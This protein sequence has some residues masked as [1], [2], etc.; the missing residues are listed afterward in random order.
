MAVPPNVA[1]ILLAD[2]AS[3]RRL[4]QGLL[5]NDEAD[6]VV[7]EAAAAAL[8]QPA[9][10]L[11]HPGEWL[12]GTVRKLS[13]LVRRGSARRRARERLAARSGVDPHDPSALVAQAELV[14]DVGAA[15][16]ALDEPFRSA[17]LMRYWH[18][19]SIDAIA[20]RLRVPRNTV[21]SRL[22]RG[23]ARLRERL[24]HEYGERKRWAPALCA[25]LPLHAP[26]FAAFTLCVMNKKVL[27]GASAVL[28]AALAIPFLL[29]E[30]TLQVTPASPT[31]GH[32]AVVTAP[33]LPSAADT[34]GQPAPRREAV[35]GPRPEA[36]TTGTLVVHVQDGSE[37]AGS[38]LT[39]SVGEM[40][41]GRTGDF[42]VGVLRALTD[43]AGTARFE[44]V[45][46]GRVWVRC[47]GGFKGAEVR[48][49]ETVE[50]VLKLG[51]AT[52]TGIVVDA[53]GVGIA[54]ALV[55][56]GLAPENR[57]D[58]EAA[59][60]TAADG[61]FVVRNVTVAAVIGA[62]AHG[63]APSQL[64]HPVLN[65]T[66]ATLRIE[67]AAAGGSVGG[68]VTTAD[69]LPVRDAVVRVGEGRRDALMA[70]PQMPPLPAQVLTDAEGRFLA[71]GVPAGTAPILARAKGLAPWTGTV[72]VAAGL[73]AS[74][75]IRLL[76]GV[77]CA[78]LVRT[79]AGEPAADVAVRCG[80]EGDFLQYFARSA[81]DGSFALTGLPAG[82]IE[83]WA[84]DGERGKAAATV[85]GEHGA[86]VRC[87]LVLSQGLA[88]RGRV[89][90]EDGKPIPSVDLQCMSEG[91]GPRWWKN[92][93]TDKAGRFLVADCPQGRLLTV[94]AWMQDHVPLVRRSIDPKAGELDLKLAADTSPRA[95]ITGRIL[96]PGGVRATGVAVRAF[97]EARRQS[98]DLGLKSDDGTFALEVSA[99][100]WGV[101]VSC[102]GH[103]TVL[104][105]PRRLQPAEAWDLGTIELT[106][107][108]T[109]LVHDGGREGLGYLVL[110]AR[111]Q[112][113]CGI[114]SP[115]TPRR[116]ELLAA[117][118]YLLLVRAKG[119]GAQ[120]L[121]F[122]IRSG[123]ETAIDV[124]P[125]AGVR[126]RF[127]FVPAQGTELPPWVSFRIA[128]DG[129]LVGQ[130]IQE[131]SG[132]PR[133]G[134]V[135]LEPGDYVLTSAVEGREGQAAVTIGQNEGPP[136][137]ITLR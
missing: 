94:K 53:A 88:L 9:A 61:S 132:E 3:L 74:V 12:R 57:V 98:G 43:T 38:D 35:D 81:A 102:E 63:Y 135:W 85:N 121:P 76:P 33:L 66:G 87:E 105:G 95:R 13:L 4:A 34:A 10:S 115:A 18:D 60:I 128:R 84:E 67:L 46:P 109:L 133:R 39:V 51:G 37:P 113:L 93:R 90:E 11:R 89:T 127:E 86:T 50:C 75:T 64:Y 131:D 126:Q 130:C 62:R 27:L 72:D 5:A 106:V 78:G 103:P 36:V 136:V 31:P 69:G 122:T 99:G 49:G 73:T 25:L 100:T 80:R 40:I 6:D 68:T 65:Q 8:C 32:P 123:Q 52:V 24:D 111:E 137:R 91:E 2:A 47:N 20:A 54:G 16:H 17:V 124:K 19:L 96:G 104:A 101:R 41:G 114:Y 77:T 118:D 134:E 29:P 55:E 97:D 1:D 120:M 70:T 58:P 7:Q 107:G 92:A 28:L 129:K 71:I 26:A 45:A 15:V 48:A 108:G 21:R 79:E 116:S 22:Q 44:N 42:R 23:L 59:A 112:F 56:R 83:I 82:A 14:R 125:V 110:D 30:P 117:G 119:I